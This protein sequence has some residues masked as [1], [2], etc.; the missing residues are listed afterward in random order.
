MFDPDKKD[1]MIALKKE[2]PIAKIWSYLKVDGVIF[3]NEVK[4]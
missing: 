3:V 4:E 2:L 1:E